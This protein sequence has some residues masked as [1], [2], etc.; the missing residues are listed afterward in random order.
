[1]IISYVVRPQ[2]RM[3]LVTHVRSPLRL[4]KFTA[5]ERSC[6]LRFVVLILHLLPSVRF[7]PW[8]GANMGPI[9]ESTKESR[10]FT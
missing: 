7:L 9:Q 3:I 8:H 6:I 5:S 10:D 2:E 1:M 4:F